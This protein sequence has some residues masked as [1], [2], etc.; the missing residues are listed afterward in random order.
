MFGLG[1]R[2]KKRNKERRKME[3]ADIE[4]LKKVMEKKPYLI[5]LL[6]PFERKVMKKI[7]RELDLPPEGDKTPSA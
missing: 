6:D 4:K 1:M 3:K 2:I 7:L 5:D